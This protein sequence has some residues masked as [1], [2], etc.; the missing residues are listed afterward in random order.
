MPI[1]TTPTDILALLQAAWQRE[2]PLEREKLRVACFGAHNEPT[3]WEYTADRY[4]RAR[5]RTVH[6]RDCGRFLGYQPPSDMLTG[7]EQL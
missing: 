4:G 5:F 7:E 3:Q 6:C 1:V 2:P